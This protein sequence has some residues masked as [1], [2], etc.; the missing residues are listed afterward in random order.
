MPT[1]RTQAITFCAA[2]SPPSNL[3]ELFVT[4]RSFGAASLPYRDS[5][6]LRAVVVKNAVGEGKGVSVESTRETRELTN[7]GDGDALLGGGFADFCQSQLVD[8]QPNGVVHPA[9]D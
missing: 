6:S 8:C 1:S 9:D 2:N 4:M 3:L 7:D 5:Q